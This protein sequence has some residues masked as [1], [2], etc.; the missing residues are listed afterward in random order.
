MQEEDVYDLYV[1]SRMLRKKALAPL[2]INLHLDLCPG[3]V[4]MSG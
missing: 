4:P 2:A 1:H 3:V